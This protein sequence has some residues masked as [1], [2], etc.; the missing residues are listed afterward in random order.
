MHQLNRC[1][2]TRSHLERIV[3]P[4]GR[5]NRDT[6]PWPHPGA[7]RKHSMANRLAQ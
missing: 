6:K 2:G 7:A 5:R 3:R 4:A 1:T